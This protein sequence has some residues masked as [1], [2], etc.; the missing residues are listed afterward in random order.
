MIG[1]AAPVGSPI[2]HVQ[3]VLR[4]ELESR[5][6]TVNEIHLSSL[7]EVVEDRD[8]EPAAH[9][10]EYERIG[11][12]M[13]RGNAL[14]AR[15]NGGEVLAVLAVAEISNF[16]DPGDELPTLDGHAFVLRQ[17]KPLSANIR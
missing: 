5:D 14:R 15:M 16:R 4:N 10:T 17:L 9:A 8:Q 11:E 3:R 13:D 2:N 12:L 6:Y 7:I 1:L